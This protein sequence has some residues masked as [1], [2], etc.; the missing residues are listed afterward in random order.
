MRYSQEVKETA[1]RRVLPPRSEPVS[2]VAREIGISQQT[3]YAWKQEAVKRGVNPTNSEADEKFTSNDKFLMVVQTM[4]MSELEISEF[5]RS[6]GV[7]VEQIQA[8]RS[9][10]QNAN[11]NLALETVRLQKALKAAEQEKKQ[12]QK[13]L[14]KKNQALA[15]MATLQVLEKK[16]RAIWGGQ[17]AE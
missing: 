4:S 14:D 16:T 6:K 15:E 11:G 9:A 10:C 2:T 8:W 1:L 12:L 13:D 5:A 17:K 7:F 3:L